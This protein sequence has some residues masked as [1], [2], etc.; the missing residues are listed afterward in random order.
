MKKT[1]YIL[2]V[3]TGIIIG[4]FISVLYQLPAYEKTQIYLKNTLIENIDLHK[5]LKDCDDW[6]TYLEKSEICCLDVT[7]TVYNAVPEQTNDDNFTTASMYKLDSINQY[8]HKI[9]AVSRDLLKVYPFGSRVYI[10]G[11]KDYD[12]VYKVEDLMNKRYK[13]SIDILINIDMKL[14]KWNNVTLTKL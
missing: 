3:L 11:T 8:K 7:A 4:F 13:N 9:I 5:E 2:G 10:H 14:G 12:G 6:V 1:T